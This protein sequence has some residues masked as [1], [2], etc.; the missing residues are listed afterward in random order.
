MPAADGDV[1]TS[2]PP[3]TATT[4]PPPGARRFR[5]LPV[6]PF[7]AEG[8]GIATF[9]KDDL[10]PDFTGSEAMGVKALYLK[11]GQE[12]PADDEWGAIASW[13]W[14]ASRVMDYLETNP[15]ID[16]MLMILPYLRGIMLSLPTV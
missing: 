7:L 8:I 5:S 10:A 14:G 3:A 1:T 6:E 11:P 2:P 4:G 16:A 15:A 13:A 9:N 12:K